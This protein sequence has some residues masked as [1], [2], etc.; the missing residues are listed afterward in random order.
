MGMMA[1]GG[2]G[3]GG[4]GPMFGG[5]PRVGRAVR[6]ARSPAS[7]RSCRTVAQKILDDRAGARRRAGHVRPDPARRA[8]RSRCAASSR[9]TS[10]GCSARS[11]FVDHRDVAT[12]AGPLLTAIADRPT[13][14]ATAI[15]RVAL[16]RSP[17]IYLATVVFASRRR[18]IRLA[19]TG[20]VGER[21]MFH[22]RVRIFTHLQRLALDFYTREKAG[23]S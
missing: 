14:S 17:R 22:L 20:R 19:W 18:R 10:G 6:A 3:P 23:G 13:A 1:S 16:R 4:G 8:T 21:L 7:R 5:G 2:G 9:R 15:F 11:L 12:Q